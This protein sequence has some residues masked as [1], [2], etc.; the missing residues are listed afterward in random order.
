MKRHIRIWTVLILCAAMCLLLAS[1]GEKSS[2]SARTPA[3]DTP[4]VVEPSNHEVTPVTTAPPE[5][6]AENGFTLESYIKMIQPMIDKLV[7]QASQEGMKMEVTA[8]GNSLVYIYQYTTDLGVD[9][10]VI[11]AALDVQLDNVDDTFQELLTSLQSQVPSAEAVVVHYLDLNG[12]IITTRVWD[13]S[14]AAPAAPSTV[15]PGG[16]SAQS[17]ELE[18]YLGYIQ[19]ELDAQS[20]L[21]ESQGL[22]MKVVAEGNILVYIYQYTED[23]GVDNAF[24]RDGLD[25]ELDKANDA[26]VE[27]L[28][29]IQTEVPSIEA[30]TVQYLDVYG[31]LIT[32]WTWDVNGNV[33]RTGS[34]NNPDLERYLESIR[35]E[36]DAQLK[37]YEEQGLKTEVMV[38]GNA[39]VYSYRYTIDLGADNETIADLLDSQLEELSDVFE[40]DLIALREAI[41]STEAV[42]VR[43]LDINGQLI[44]TR[45]WTYEDTL[46]SF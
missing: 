30:M 2:V 21:Y 9:N 17:S 7:E 46:E 33:T 39:L 4:T 6:P 26:F 1:C 35:D 43:Y 14:T 15:P 22:K 36:L 12:D 8:E 28:A 42:I 5:E 16:S 32:S 40:G 34:A 23:L 20:R 18:R 44:T 29:D 24:A 13:D 27:A 10:S 31:S 41:P 25:A 37:P 11:K 38:E 3:E 45:Q 19:S